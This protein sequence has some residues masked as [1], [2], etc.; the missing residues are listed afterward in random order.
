MAAGSPSLRI[1]TNLTASCCAGFGRVTWNAKLLWRSG[2]QVAPG[3]FS[4]SRAGMVLLLERGCGPKYRSD[5]ALKVVRMAATHCA[6]CSMCCASSRQNRWRAGVRGSQNT[7]LSNAHFRHECH[8]YK[9]ISRQPRIWRTGG[10]ARPVSQAKCTRNHCA[11]HATC[12]VNAD[13]P[14]LMM[15]HQHPITTRTHYELQL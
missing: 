10:I 13:F 8:I 4:L 7:C 12:S 2:A 15:Q 6:S 1:C 9:S 14:S 5:R 3:N 11:L